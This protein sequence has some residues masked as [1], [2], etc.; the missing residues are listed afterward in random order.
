MALTFLQTAAFVAISLIGGP[1]NNNPDKIQGVVLDK[2]T[3]EPL[4]FAHVVIGD[5]RTVT[6][7]DGEFAITIPEAT[8]QELAVS[9]IGYKTYKCP[10]DLADKRFQISLEPSLT[11]LQAVEVT[12]GESILEKVF[13]TLRLNYELDQQHMVCY[14]K[15]SLAETSGLY[16]LAEGI[17]DVFQPSDVSSEDIEISPIKTRKQEFMPID[18]ELVLVHGHASDM[19][20][21]IVRREKS[22]VQED[23]FRHYDYQYEGISEYN[24]EEVLIISFEPNSKKANTRGFLYVDGESYAVI[25]AEYFP[26]VEGHPFW[27]EV[28]WTEEFSKTGVM[29][30]LNRVTYSGKWTLD[31]VQYM[32]ESMLVVNES[33]V[34][35]VPPALGLLLGEKDVFFD[36]ASDFSE[37]F[38]EE[39]NYIKLSKEE[40]STLQLAG[41]H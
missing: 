14:Y 40:K 5:I 31:E 13:N 18:E 25:K 4:P 27:D 21:S 23:N 3:Q 20:E 22:F 6:N 34:V 33:Q 1:K 19:L 2:E 32:Y 12:T 30:N 35:D 17:L 26:L 24:G 7:V 38:W 11:Q 41:S 37:D 9:F 39:H 10:V 29:W 36:A 8:G 16:Y 15:E 28:S